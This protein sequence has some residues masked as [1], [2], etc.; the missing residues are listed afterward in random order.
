MQHWHSARMSITVTLAPALRDWLAGNLARGTSPAAMIEALVARQFEPRVAQG[1]IAAFVD[2]QAAGLPLPQHSV[3]L[4][5]ELP[6]YDYGTPRIAAGNVIDAAGH[7]A[8][9]LLRLVQPV[10]VTLEG[11]LSGTE[12]E[13]LIALARP[14]LSRSTVLDPST[15]TN[16]VAD[17][18]NSDGMF[19]GLGENPFIAELDRRVSVLMNCPI[20]NG[21]GLQVLRYGT[22]GYTAPHFDFLIPSSAHNSQSIA[23]SG[24]RVST[25]IVYL[26]DVAEGGETVFPQVGL[27]VTP[28]QGNA[29]YFEYANDRLQ[30]DPRSLHAGAP[31]LR[32]E[33]WVVTKWMRQRRFAPEPGP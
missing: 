8:R 21:E 15:G 9:V 2:A 24:Q 16:A 26:N 4:G 28:R 3:E 31:V 19:F 32:G 29:L 6:A 5:I 11:V 17:Y 7:A 10:I 25:L 14:R 30:V 33:K 13:R 18:R 23:R 22:G 12:C 1:L 27:A 20:E